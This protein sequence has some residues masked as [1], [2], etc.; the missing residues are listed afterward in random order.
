MHILFDTP[1]SDAPIGQVGRRQSEHPIN[2]LTLRRTHN[3]DPL[4]ILRIILITHLVRWLSERPRNTILRRHRVR[5]TSTHQGAAGDQLERSPE[6][7][8]GVR[9]VRVGRYM[10]VGWCDRR[11]CA[12]HIRLAM[13]ICG[14]NDPTCRAWCATRESIVFGLCVTTMA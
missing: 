2:G 10:G 3:A 8:E 4:S 5:W 13:M 1:Q 9:A 6:L 12:V 14:Y 7:L 11:L